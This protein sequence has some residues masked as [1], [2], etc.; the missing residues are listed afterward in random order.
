MRRLDLP[1]EDLIHLYV[2]E[3]LTCEEVANRFNCASGVIFNRLREYGIKLRSVGI[4]RLDI[5]TEKLVELYTKEKLSTW[6][7]AEILKCSRFMVHNRL[8]AFGITRDLATSHI[9]YPRVS[10]SG[11]KSEKAYLI[12]FTIGDLRIRKNGEKSKTVKIDCASTKEEQI[13]LIQNLF[14]KYGRV[15]ISKPS[16]ANKIQIEVHVD[17]S[18]SFLLDPHRYV[19]EN[20][21]TKN[22]FASFL[23]GFSDAEGS[24]YISKNQGRFSIGNYN[25]K[26]LDMIK[27]KLE[28]YNIRS[29]I[30]CDKNLRINN[31]GY[32]RNNFYYILSVNRKDSLLKLINLIGY[33]IK[34]QKR[35]KDMYLVR[36]NILSR[37][38][39]FGLNN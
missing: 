39:I 10:F 38:K 26:L 20:F 30:V 34:H 11:S 18:F 16:K 24:F 12:G 2:D 7:I 31:E 29:T 32:K 15:W 3:K 13:Q 27:R 36:E 6:K 23:A 37:N 35:T 22:L 17:F 9:I 25:I 28:S 33:K 8:Q 19:N 5:T 14:S 4:P 1:R 21:K